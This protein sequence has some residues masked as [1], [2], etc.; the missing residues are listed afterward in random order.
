[1]LQ[2]YWHNYL[3]QQC[4]VWLGGGEGACYLHN[5]LT[6]TFRVWLGGVGR[7]HATYIFTCLSHLVFGW[8]GGEGA[9]YL[10]NYLT[11]TFRVWLGGGEGACYLH[12]YLSQPFSV[13]LGGGEGSCCLH[14]YLTQPFSVWLGGGKGA[15]YLHN[16]LTQPFRSVYIYTHIHT[17]IYIYIY[18]R[19]HMYVYIYIIERRGKDAGYE[20]R[21]FGKCT[22]PSHLERRVARDMQGG[23]RKVGCHIP[24]YIYIYMIIYVCLLGGWF[25]DR[26]HV[27][28]LWHL[29]YLHNL[30]VNLGNL[31]F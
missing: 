27:N 2:C 6:Q 24:S 23:R 16:Y 10:H 30:Q 11:Q 31:T 26:I 3:T 15:C 20:I 5:Y 21:G 12:I 9:C 7:E 25:W 4:R 8:G 19:T 14:N 29:T 28:Y 18:T 22:Q 13:W 17:H 1:M